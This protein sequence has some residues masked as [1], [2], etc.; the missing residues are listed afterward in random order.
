[1]PAAPNTVCREMRIDPVDLGILLAYLAATVAFGI[2]VG[3]RQRTS[4]DYMLGS[5]SLPWWALMLSIVATETSTVT[6]LSVPGIT[7]LPRGD[8]TFLQLP[9]GYVL[10]RLLICVILLPQYFAGTNVTAYDV[11]NRRF[12]GATQ[13]VA[14]LLFVVTRTLADG[15]RLFLA[16]VVLQSVSGFDLNWSI[17][18]FGLVTLGFT[19][20]GGIRAVVWT[21]VV[22]FAVYILGAAAALAV[23]VGLLDGGAGALFDVPDGKLRVFDAALDFTKP[24]TL[25]AGVLAGTFVAFGTHGVDQLMV[26]R[27]LC[28]K[29]QRDAGLALGTSGV[30]VLLQFVFF[31][32]VG[33]GLYAFYQPAQ[34][35][36]AI[37][38]GAHPPS[39]PFDDQPQKQAFARFIID[40]LPVGVLGL[41]LG[42][43][44]SAAISTLSSSINSLAT[45]TTHDLWV[46]RFAPDA[47][48]ATRLALSRRFTLL[49]ALLQVGVGIGGQGISGSIIDRVLAIQSFTIGIVLGVFFLGRFVP[50]ARQ[51]N[52]LLAIAVGL[53]AVSF[54]AFGTPVAWPW[55]AVIGSGTTLA[56][57]WIA[58][59]ATRR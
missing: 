45:A 24:Y 19:L 6:F 46:P 58:S 42:A 49:F 30:V 3:G 31:L 16:A 18:L 36:D 48:D 47:D 50:G 11:L 51:G 27:Y 20:V 21:D 34:V 13:R 55:L 39:V 1:M 25:W 22:Q 29:S 2:W 32:V 5:R 53:G 43:V 4:A 35:G 40:N 33:L 10:G 26:Q 52:A 59:I 9:L 44:F 23:L 7:F 15:L 17:A 28:A 38:I 56:V 8:F 57:G 54:V 14:S 41:V 37:V 12:G